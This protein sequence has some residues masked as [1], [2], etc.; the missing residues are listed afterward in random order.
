MFYFGT[1]FQ[2][3]LRD[4]N[5]AAFITLKYR[6][7]CKV[8]IRGVAYL[9]QLCTLNA[10]T[11]KSL[12][13]SMSDT[14]VTKGWRRNML[15]HTAPEPCTEHMCY[16]M[17]LQASSQNMHT[18]VRLLFGHYDDYHSPPCVFLMPPTSSQITTFTGI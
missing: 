1:M 16:G 10:K 14:T 4:G 8:L 7:F 5:V 9:F 12:C 11:N 2:N 13:L 15:A 17:V 18:N 6:I 3:C